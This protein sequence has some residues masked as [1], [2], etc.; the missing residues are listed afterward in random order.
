[1]PAPDDVTG[2]DAGIPPPD[3]TI[4]APPEADVTRLSSTQVPEVRAQRLE[5]SQSAIGRLVAGEVRSTQGAVGLVRGRSV[6]IA[7]GAVGAVA[8]EHVETRGG[9]TFLMLSRHVS[10][11]VRVLLDWRSAAATVGA[12]LVIGRLLRGRR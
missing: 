1:M 11:D 2:T 8:A 3:V 9:F 5:A 7:E 6:E 12:L 4:D 10:G